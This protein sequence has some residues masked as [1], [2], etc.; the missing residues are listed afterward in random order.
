MNSMSLVKLAKGKG[1]V[2]GSQAT[3][4][5]F[6]RSPIDLLS[7]AK[8]L[9]ITNTTDALAT[10]RGNCDRVLQHAHLRKT[11]KGVAELVEM[12]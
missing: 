2:F 6:Q 3:A 10:V 4:T 12:K 7:L 1:I 8:L 9:G 5:V 11:F